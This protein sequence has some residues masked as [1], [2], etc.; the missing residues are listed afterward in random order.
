MDC[1]RS[2]PLM[3]LGMGSIFSGARVLPVVLIL[4]ATSL[5][6]LFN[7]SYPMAIDH[8]RYRGAAAGIAAA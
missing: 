5:Q 2:L 8:G 1:N 6:C 7:G 4:G 3:R